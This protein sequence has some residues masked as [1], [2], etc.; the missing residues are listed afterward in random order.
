MKDCLGLWIYPR[1]IHVYVIMASECLCGFPFPWPWS[2]NVANMHRVYGIPGMSLDEVL[3]KLRGYPQQGLVCQNC[4]D[5]LS[6]PDRIRS[7]TMQL[8]LDD[9]TK[10]E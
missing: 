4:L 2:G 1:S 10:R 9:A 7:I 6:D 8:W 5:M 3:D